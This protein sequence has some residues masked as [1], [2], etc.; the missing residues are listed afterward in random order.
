VFVLKAHQKLTHIYR[1]KKNEFTQ[2]FFKAIDPLRAARRLGRCC[3]S[4]LRI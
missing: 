1:L 4:C 3:S 2:V